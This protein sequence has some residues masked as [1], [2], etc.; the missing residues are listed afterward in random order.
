MGKNEIVLF[1]SRD[2]AVSLPVSVDSDTVWL[3]RMQMANLFGVTPQNITI[4]LG[5]V[6]SAGELDR[7][8]TSKESLLVQ[9]EGGRGSG[10]SPAGSQVCA[11][12][13]DR[14]RK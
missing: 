2:G 5:K 7:A 4:H 3:T 13:G 6:Y 10:G 9:D 14:I 12:S 8:A 1:E 11:L